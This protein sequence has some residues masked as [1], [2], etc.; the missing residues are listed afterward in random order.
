MSSVQLIGYM[1]YLS[2]CSWSQGRSPFLHPDTL[3]ILQVDGAI[4][5]A[6]QLLSSKQ[7]NQS[8]QLAK[9]QEP[10]TDYTESVQE[11]ML[12]LKQHGFAESA[13]HVADLMLGRWV[14]KAYRILMQAKLVT[15]SQTSLCRLD[16]GKQVLNEEAEDI[17]H[18]FAEAWSK[19]ASLPPGMPAL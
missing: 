4:L 13:R 10:Q 9:V 18:R 5:M 2:L 14:T 17:A 19:V 15:Y 6:R 1:L 3:I 11:S 7:A 16:M 12:F 8:Q